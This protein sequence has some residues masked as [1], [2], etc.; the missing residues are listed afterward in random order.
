MLPSSR[1]AFLAWQ[2]CAAA[3]SHGCADTRQIGQGH[4]P[5]FCKVR[6]NHRRDV[7]GPR[8]QGSLCKRVSTRFEPIGRQPGGPVSVLSRH[9]VG[10]YGV[11]QQNSCLPCAHRWQRGDEDAVVCISVPVHLDI[12]THNTIH[13]HRKHKTSHEG[14]RQGL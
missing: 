5:A 14:I 1:G 2:A 10:R 4:G 7:R 13:R 11:G 3:L 8:L 9:L 6:S 12:S